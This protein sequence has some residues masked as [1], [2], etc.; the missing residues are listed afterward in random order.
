M[1]I[2]GKNTV[3]SIT[4]TAR[5]DYEV[6]RD[7]GLTQPEFQLYTY[8]EDV[9]RLLFEGGLYVY[10]LHTEYQCQPEY[11]GV[12]SDLIKYMKTK[13][14]WVTTASEIYNWWIRKNKLE[15]RV[16]N[17]SDTR[18]AVTVTNPGNEYLEEF[19]VELDLQVPAKNIEI[20]SEIIGTE[21]PGYDYDPATHMIYLHVR[22]LKPG[23]SRLYYIDFDKVN[24]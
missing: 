10:K 16:E 20:T 12:V 19:L 3:I 9:D 8:K 2:K 21:I 17:R 24:V 13:K 11:V 4:K 22:N 18:V 1:V 7:Y 6:I 14:I 15:M 23:Q 5:D